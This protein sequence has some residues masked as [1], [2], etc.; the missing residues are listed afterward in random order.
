MI[1]IANAAVEQ[2]SPVQD[3][4]VVVAPALNSRL[5]HWLSDE[6]DARAA[7]EERLASTLASL[8]RSG[9][10]ASGF[11]GDADPLRALADALGL[12]E[13]ECVTIA[14][15]AEPNWLARDLV[16]RARLRFGVPVR[17]LG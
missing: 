6:D 7:A 16:E 2:L 15:S 12:Y 5:R 8:R 4:V 11:I 1:L 14:A 10:E 9:V 3:E 13:A 17:K